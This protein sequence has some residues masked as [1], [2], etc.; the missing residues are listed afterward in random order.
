[1]LQGDDCHQPASRARVN[2]S[3]FDLVAHSIIATK[4]QLVFCFKGKGGGG[5]EKN[6]SMN[7]VLFYFT[8]SS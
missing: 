4:G 6:G 5:V 2:C 3:V 1:M 7:P 8:F